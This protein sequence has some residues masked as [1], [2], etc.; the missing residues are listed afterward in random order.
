MEFWQV[1][2]YGPSH[3]GQVG[4]VLAD[5]TEPPPVYLDPGSGPGF[6]Q[7]THWSVYDGALTGPRAH[8]LRA[9]CTCGWRGTQ[10]PVDW[11][12]M[13]DE[14][15]RVGGARDADHCQSDWDRHVFE[16]GRT[17]VPVPP[18]LEGRLADLHRELEELAHTEPIAVLKIV[19]RLESIASHT[20]YSAALRA[21]ET[22]GIEEVAKGLGLTEKDAL[23]RL[24]RHRRPASDLP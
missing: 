18:A 15:L 20:A 23:L 21:D 10:Y 12:A 6:V 17:T 13:G 19:N 11:T 22:L 4:V 1:D 5:G 3:Q 7:T 14:P 16:V 8:A 9:A 2:E 24:D